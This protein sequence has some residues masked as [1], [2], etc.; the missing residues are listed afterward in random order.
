[1]KKIL[2]FLL[3]IL[4]AAALN[5]QIPVLPDILQHKFDQE[6]L[7]LTATYDETENINSEE[8]YYTYIDREIGVDTLLGYRWNLET[9]EWDLNA[10]IIDTYDAGELLVEKLF[11]IWTPEG[12]WLDGLFFQYTYNDDGNLTE[13]IIQYWQ[14]DSAVWINHFRKTQTYNDNG[15]LTDINTFWWPCWGEEGWIDHQHKIFTY[16][17]DV[18]V[19]DTVQVFHHMFG[20]WKDFLYNEFT[21]N[22]GGLKIQK[23][24]YIMMMMG[25]DWITNFRWNY[26]YDDAGNIT[27]VTGQNWNWFAEEWSDFDRY[28]YTWDDAGKVT[29][30]LYEYWDFFGS[31][32]NGTVQIDYSYNDAG[33]LS[34]YVMQYKLMFLDEWVNGK[35]EFFTYD[36]DGNMIEKIVQFWDAEVEDWVNF[37]KWEMLLDYKGGIT[38]IGDGLTSDGIRAIYRNPYQHGDNISFQGLEAGNYTI[39]VTDIYGRIIESQAYSAGQSISI[40]SGLPA[41]TN[42]LM[43]SGNARILCTGKIVTLK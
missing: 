15:L 28:N 11:Q 12:T 21:Y 13:M 22:D 4:F 31:S 36:G 43:L 16:A 19:A 39:T 1:M 20:E 10:R 3:C 42:I 24:N 6:K 17:E 18:L 38:G 7:D 14:P 5:A 9:G 30:Y 8:E 33:Y 41:G 35:Q 40:R 34:Q 23:T 27:Q 2:P 25:D 32:W 37:E 29:Y 26:T